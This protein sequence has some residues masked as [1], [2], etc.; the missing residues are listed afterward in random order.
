VNLVWEDVLYGALGFECEL[1]Y[2]VFGLP[3]LAGLGTN[4]VMGNWSMDKNGT[5]NGQWKGSG[6]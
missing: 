5:D 6:D 2:L 3:C 4:E 1:M